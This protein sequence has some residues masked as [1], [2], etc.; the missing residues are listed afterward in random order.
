MAQKKLDLFLK[1]EN[2]TDKNGVAK[3]FNK[4]IVVI[5]DIELALTPADNTV[6]QV[7]ANYFESL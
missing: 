6:R 2:Y 5:N 7:L 4:Y 1:V 3:T